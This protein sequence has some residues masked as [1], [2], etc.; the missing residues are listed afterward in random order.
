MHTALGDYANPTP[1]EPAVPPTMLVPATALRI[2]CRRT[3]G[4]LSRA[5]FYRW[6][7]DGRI[8]SMR[9][10]KHIFIPCPPW[11]NLFV[12]TGTQIEP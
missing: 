8:R 12:S 5:T 9:L 1:L 2:L 3:G 11:K 4:T 7:T 6:I 10:G